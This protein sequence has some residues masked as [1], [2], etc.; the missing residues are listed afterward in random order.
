MGR[1]ALPEES[2]LNEEAPTA[3]GSEAEGRR[4]FILAALPESGDTSPPG[5]PCLK[6]E[7]GPMLGS[8][9]AGH[10][11]FI[12]GSCLRMGTQPALGVLSEMGAPL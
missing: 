11:G 6:G 2:F 8:E 10:Y 1:Q 5:D 7:C 9:E 4:G 12:L 3:R